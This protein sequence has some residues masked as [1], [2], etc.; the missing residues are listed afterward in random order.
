MTSIEHGMTGEHVIGHI[1]AGVGYHTSCETDSTW[2]SIN[3]K[4]S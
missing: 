2:V 4:M 1:T 3:I